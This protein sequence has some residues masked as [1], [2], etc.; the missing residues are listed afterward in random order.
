MAYN[1]HIQVVACIERR[2]A[3]I[4]GVPEAVCGPINVLQYQIGQ[5][6]AVHHDWGENAPRTHTALLYLCASAPY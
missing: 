4:V 5:R 3:G 6:Y 1:L 2:I